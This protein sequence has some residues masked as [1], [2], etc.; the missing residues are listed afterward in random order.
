[1][2]IYNFEVKNSK[3][4]LQYEECISFL[5][6]KIIKGRSTVMPYKKK[7]FRINRNE[8]KPYNAQLILENPAK[9]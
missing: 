4:L 3:T 8:A 2:I 5:L 9:T 1:M 6:K 7:V